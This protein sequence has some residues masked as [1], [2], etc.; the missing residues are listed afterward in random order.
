[1]PSLESN[2]LLPLQSAKVVGPFSVP[3]AQSAKAQQSAKA[4]QVKAL[5]VCV[6]PAGK[7]IGAPRS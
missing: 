6:R 2:G 1:M 5:L 7:G 4:P 3:K